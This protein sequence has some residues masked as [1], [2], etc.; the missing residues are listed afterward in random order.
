VALLTKWFKYTKNE[1][2][3]IELTQTINNSRY[4]LDLLE[5]IIRDEITEEEKTKL[6]DYNSPSWAYR[7]ADRNGA[8]RVL[9]QILTLIKRTN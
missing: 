8:L 3:R 7:Q 1:Q 9:R 2:E 6:D 5:R 4:I